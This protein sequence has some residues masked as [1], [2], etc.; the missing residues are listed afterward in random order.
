MNT[1]DIVP[2]I[3]KQKIN[4]L[5]MCTIW[6]ASP[7]NRRTVILGLTFPGRCL[8]WPVNMQDLIYL[9]GNFAVFY[10][11]HVKNKNNYF[12]KVSISKMLSKSSFT[13]RLH[14][15]IKKKKL[16]QKLVLTRLIK[17]KSLSDKRSKITI[18]NAN[19][20]NN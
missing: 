12:D 11:L 2:F 6:N 14:L 9:F 1:S 7:V 15:G 20:L 10:D 13:W 8:Y 4:D 18:L 5:N 19:L 17:A 16:K 3:W